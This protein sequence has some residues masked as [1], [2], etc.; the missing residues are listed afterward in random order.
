MPPE[1]LEKIEVDGV[2]VTIPR[3]RV[4]YLITKTPLGAKKVEPFEKVPFEERI[5]TIL[6]RVGAGAEEIGKRIAE[7]VKAKRSKVKEVV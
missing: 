6:K 4:A 5:A 7:I 3:E 1:E 2:V